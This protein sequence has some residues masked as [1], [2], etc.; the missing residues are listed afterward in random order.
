M[1]TSIK[2]QT[3]NQ[4]CTENPMVFTS[5]EKVEGKMDVWKD[6]FYRCPEF[7]DLISELFTGV[8]EDGIEYLREYISNG[9]EEYYATSVKADEESK[10]D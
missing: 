2:T 10:Q 9:F 4:A 3:Q 6:I 7:A 1:E 5:S 8:G